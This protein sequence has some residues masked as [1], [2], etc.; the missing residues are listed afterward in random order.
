MRR[1]SFDS[2]AFALGVYA[3]A[4]ALVAVSA[5]TKRSLLARMP[6]AI[7]IVVLLVVFGLA[8]M[9]TNLVAWTVENHIHS[10]LALVPAVPTLAVMV[11]VS[12]GV[13]LVPTTDEWIVNLFPL[14]LAG[15]FMYVVAMRR[16]I[17]YL[18][19]HERVLAEW[20]A[21]PDTRYIWV[22]RT[23]A[24]IGAVVVIVCGLVISFDF[25]EV[26]TFFGIFGG[27]LLGWALA[28]GRRRQYTLFESGLAVRASGTIN[29][30]FVSLGRLRS[31]SRSK[32]ALT[33]R[34]RL[35]W[36]FSFR[37]SVTA[38]Q[39]PDAIESTLRERIE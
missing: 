20:T 2:F 16:Y 34:R 19:E 12:F 25:G 36:P 33:I 30:M 13:D 22:I 6:L 5:V 18:R 31:V 14:L 3:G 9:R 15:L 26:T 32:R 38:I 11:A 23:V 17:A 10:V 35:P 28:V 1:P 24:V 8:A 29:G 37:S 27:L 39:N 4:V 7:A 21:P